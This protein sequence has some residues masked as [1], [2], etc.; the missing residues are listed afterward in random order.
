[1]DIFSNLMEKTFF[2]PTTRKN[3]SIKKRNMIFHR[4]GME[5]QKSIFLFQIYFKMLCFEFSIFFS[6]RN[7]LPINKI[8]SN[9]KFEKL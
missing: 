9:L 1:M 8:Q 6:T 2:Y 5:N 3:F 7:P 4:K